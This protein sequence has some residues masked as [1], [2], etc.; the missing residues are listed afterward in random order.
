MIRNTNRDSKKREVERLNDKFVKEGCTLTE[1]VNG[2]LLELEEKVDRTEDVTQR[3]SLNELVPT[4]IP[5]YAHEDYGKI[6]MHRTLT[7]VRRENEKE[8]PLLR[9][10]AL[11]HDEI[12]ATGKTVTRY[13]MTIISGK[14]Q[15]KIVN[16]RIEKTNEANDRIMNGNG[17]ASD[18][19]AVTKERKTYLEYL[20]HKRKYGGTK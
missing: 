13:Y 20:R 10:W 19:K 8:H 17:Q 7:H 1:R 3:P 16:D 9:M 12:S 2:V 11:A 5:I 14:K 4:F 18:V 15:V 6:L